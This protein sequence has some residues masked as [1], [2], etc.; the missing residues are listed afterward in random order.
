MAQTP[1]SG[2]SAY[3]TAAELLLFVDY[4]TLSDLCTDTDGPRPLKT[5]FSDATTDLGAKTQAILKAASGYVEMACLNGGRYTPDDLAALTGNQ[6]QA[7]KKLVANLALWDFYTRRPDTTMPEPPQAVEANRILDA[8][9]A[10]EKI[11]GTQQ[12][13]DAGRLELTVETPIDVENR[14]LV[15]FQAERMFG[16]RANRRTQP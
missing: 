16:R 9:A 7:L 8:V 10:G 14:N 12:A 13:M 2:D 6:A 3:I 15:T 11:F 5:D 1:V 4:R